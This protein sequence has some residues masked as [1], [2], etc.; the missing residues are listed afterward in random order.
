MY[1]VDKSAG[2]VR[3]MVIDSGNPRY[4]ASKH[5]SFF[6]GLTTGQHVRNRFKVPVDVHK[7]I[8]HAVLDEELFGKE[9]QQYNTLH[10][11]SPGP[12]LAEAE[13]EQTILRPD[14]M[15]Y[16]DR[17]AD[18][19]AKMKAHGSDPQLYDADAEAATVA[20]SAVDN[21]SKCSA[22]P[23][24]FYARKISDYTKRLMKEQEMR[25]HLENKIRR[26]RRQVNHN[27]KLIGMQ[28]NSDKAG[29]MA[30]VDQRNCMQSGQNYTTHPQFEAL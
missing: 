23:T 16:D 14:E 9:G 20:T 5:S 26:L 25:E 3:R 11:E 6:G 10:Q 12:Q 28:L 17:E 15:L 24:A 1:K 22:I 19:F 4:A 27:S 30:R 8:T 13:E 29:K 7:K 18:F 2:Y 21:L